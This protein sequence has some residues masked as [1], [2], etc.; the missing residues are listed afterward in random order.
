MAQIPDV[1][2][3]QPVT[4]DSLE[5]IRGIPVG[6]LTLPYIV[7]GQPEDIVSTIANRF[8]VPPSAAAFVTDV[9]AFETEPMAFDLVVGN[10]VGSALVPESVYG[11]PTIGQIWPR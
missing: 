5:L 6:P 3:N 8:P 7:T 1:V 4:I 10:P 2:L 9:D 11:E